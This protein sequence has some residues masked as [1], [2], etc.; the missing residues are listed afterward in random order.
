MRV[1]G[2]LQMRAVGAVVEG[3]GFVAQEQHLRD[4]AQRHGHDVVRMVADRCSADTSGSGLAGA[5]AAVRS[6]EAD[7]LLVTSRER[8]GAHHAPGVTV[9]F[10]DQP[11]R[12]ALT[13][14][15][16]RARGNLRSALGP[17]VGIAVATAVAAGVA[18]ASPDAPPTTCVSA[19]YEI[20]P[21]DGIEWATVVDVVLPPEHCAVGDEEY[22]LPDGARLCL[23]YR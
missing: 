9:L 19:T 5:V 14:P 8:L 18:A 12:A 2:Y 13:R 3:T 7:A 1:I 17:W 11:E 20:V 10:A 23:R 21:C 16:Q 6:G 4:W 22:P 15:P